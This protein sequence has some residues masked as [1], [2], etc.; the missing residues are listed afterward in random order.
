MKQ[1][2]VLTLKI[3][4]RV[5]YHAVKNGKPIHMDGSVEEVTSYGLLDIRT[6]D[7]LLTD[8]HVLACRRLRKKKRREFWINRYVT[9]GM[10]VHFSE[11]EA[12]QKEIMGFEERIC[13]RE[14]TAKK[15]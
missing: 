15:K 3:G 9:N 10:S 1:D 13:V 12:K 11:T 2:D 4:D 6:K 7:R 8:V 5:R 14:V